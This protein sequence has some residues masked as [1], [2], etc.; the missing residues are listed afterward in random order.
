M[1]THEDY[2]PSGETNAEPVCRRHLKAGIRLG[3]PFYIRCTSKDLAIAQSVGLALIR[4]VRCGSV[5]TQRLRSIIADRR[6]SKGMTGNSTGPLNGG[7]CPHSCGKDTSLGETLAHMIFKCPNT[8]ELRVKFH[9]LCEKYRFRIGKKKC[10]ALV[11]KECSMEAEQAAM[12][13]F[14]ELTNGM[15]VDARTMFVLLP[16]LFE[17]LIGIFQLHPYYARRK[18]TSGRPRNST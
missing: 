7:H 17:M 2:V 4:A 5:Q 13:A 6:K 15:G 12:T 3:L 16:A 8:M 11:S 18:Y 10:A 9:E 1:M 14:L